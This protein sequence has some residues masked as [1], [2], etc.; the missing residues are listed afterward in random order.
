[1]ENKHRKRFL[2]SL[3]TREMQIKTKMK[4]WELTAND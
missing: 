2:I 4:E 1:M 3:V